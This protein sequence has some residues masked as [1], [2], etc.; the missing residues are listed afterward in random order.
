MIVNILAG[1]LIV[2]NKNINPMEKDVLINYL[3]SGCQLSYFVNERFDLYIQG[4]YEPMY[5][6][7]F[8]MSKK[9]DVDLM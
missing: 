2:R 8:E 1:Q 7:L 6:L 4:G 5:K 9:F 3:N